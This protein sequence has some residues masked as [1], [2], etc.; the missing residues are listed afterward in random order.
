MLNLKL[1]IQN[2]E[3]ANINPGMFGLFYEDI[4]YACDGGISAQ[5]LENG[6]FEFREH[7]R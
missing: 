7:G 4:N 6:C 2:V 3:Q 5:M 1:E